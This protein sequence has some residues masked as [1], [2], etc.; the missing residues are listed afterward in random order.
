MVQTAL[1]TMR[2]CLSLVSITAVL[3]YILLALLFSFDIIYLCALN[4][5]FPATYCSMHFI[6][7][8]EWERYNITQTETSCS[9]I[10]AMNSYKFQW[11]LSFLM[12][13]PTWVESRWQG[14]QNLLLVLSSCIVGWLLWLE[15][16]PPKVRFDKCYHQGCDCSVFDMNLCTSQLPRHALQNSL[17]F[18]PSGEW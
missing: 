2:I 15:E 7:F 5:H 8:E 4:C 13:S 3:A 12:H 11:V 6:Q 14:K 18:F 16:I 1:I 17:L 9:F 10:D